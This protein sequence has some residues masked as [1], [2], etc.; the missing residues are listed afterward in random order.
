MIPYIISLILFALIGYV[1]GE[2]AAY[3]SLGYG[4]ERMLSSIRAFLT[5]RR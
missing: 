1:L 2:Q 4:S 5:R 3:R